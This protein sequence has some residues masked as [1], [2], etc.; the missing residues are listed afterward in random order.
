MRVKR[1][2]KKKAV[3]IIAAV[4]L[5]LI[6]CIGIVILMLPKIKIDGGNGPITLSYM[7]VF[8]EDDAKVY[9]FG[10]KLKGELT[11]DG[12][13][14]TTKLGTY[15]VKYTFKRG[16]VKISKTKVYNVV[17]NNNPIIE[18]TGD[19][20]KTI[21]PNGSYDE[22]G[23]RALDDYDGDIT[24]K[25]LINTDDANK[26]I[27][28]VTDSSNNTGTN[29]RILNRVDSDKPTITLKSGETVYVTLNTSYNELGFSATDNCDGDL[30]ENVSV[31]GD[32]NTAVAGTYTKTYTVTDSSGNV[33]TA[34]RNVIVRAKT[35][36]T[37]NSCPG[38]PGVIYLTF[39]DGPNSY[40]TPV[41]LDVLK[42]Y[43]VK[44]TFFV[45]MAGPD[46]LIKREHDEGHVVGLHTASHDYKTVYST[47][48]GYFNDLNR[49]SDR[50]FNITGIRSKIIRFPGG[51]SNTVSKRY[52]TGIMS[53][54]TKEVEARGY[55]YFDWNISSGDAGETTD[56]NVEYNNV[57]K[58]LSK[59]C[60]NVI[61]MHDI[62]KHT[63]LAIE[64]IVKYGL[65]NGYKFDVLTESTVPSH[66]RVNN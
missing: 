24:S 55:V 8:E 46:S 26:V 54:L 51:S 6:A 52:A 66:Q 16:I 1:K 44:A 64:N 11:I 27:Y 40:Y 19:T 60:G 38:E 17:D 58:S 63:S 2:V 36:S 62:K 53:T 48:D 42:K 59:S 34:T 25:V 18:L 33:A 43:N 56:P 15:Y 12:N 22:E 20:E 3:V 14:D 30:T 50:V 23:Y 39:D 29:E 10:K 28:T 37:S 41:I 61:L 45:T 7:D 57:I 31:T 4:V 21:C 9:R 32:V 47:V 13:V 49:V 5:A 65:D 35:A